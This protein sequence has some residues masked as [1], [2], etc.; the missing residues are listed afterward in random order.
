MG[1]TI[2]NSDHFHQLYIKSPYPFKEILVTLYH[3]CAVFSLE[4]QGGFSS[5]PPPF[6]TK[7]EARF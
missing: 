1:E 3:I 4:P 7:I 6:L 2:F 5:G